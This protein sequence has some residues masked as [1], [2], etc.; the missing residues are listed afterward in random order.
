MFFYHF[1]FDALKK[2]YKK[3]IVDVIEVDFSIALLQSIVNIIRS[4]N[5]S[6]YLKWS[7][8]FEKKKEKNMNEEKTI[9]H[10]C[11]THLLGTTNRKL[12]KINIQR[13]AMPHCCQKFNFKV[14]AFNNC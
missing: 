3:K 1:F 11:S 14:G 9:V 5:L 7:W 10:V 12:K 8:K 6:Q 13:F 4:S 2:K